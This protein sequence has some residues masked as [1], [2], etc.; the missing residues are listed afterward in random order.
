VH[1]LVVFDDFSSQN[2]N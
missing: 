1:K 2:F